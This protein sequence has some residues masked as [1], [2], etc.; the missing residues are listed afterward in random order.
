MVFINN[1]TIL[2]QEIKDQIPFRIGEE[3]F[4]AVG[5][6]CDHGSG[7]EQLKYCMGLG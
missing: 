4:N 7:D 3:L 1:H 6:N 5:L 2:I